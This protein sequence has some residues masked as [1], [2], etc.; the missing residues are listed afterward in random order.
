MPLPRVSTALRGQDIAFVAKTL[1][2]WLRRC[3]S[4]WIS[5]AF[6]AGVAQPELRQQVGGTFATAFR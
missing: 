1:P 2:S 5:K 3:L 4:V 6:A